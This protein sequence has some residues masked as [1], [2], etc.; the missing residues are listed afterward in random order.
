[1]K[2]NFELSL[3][4]KGK[5]CIKFTHHE[6]NSSLEQKT[7]RLFIDGINENG[8]VLINTGGYLDSGY[9]YKN[10]EIQIDK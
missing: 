7:L 1:M 10:Y 9:S 4:R 5:P 3:D 6:K 8:C 2:A